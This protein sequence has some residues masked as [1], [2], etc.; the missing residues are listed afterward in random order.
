MSSA[1]FLLV[2]I[3]IYPSVLLY[4]FQ[5]ALFGVTAWLTCYWFKKTLFW[6]S[7]TLRLL[8]LTVVLLPVQGLNV[9]LMQ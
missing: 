1:R 4:N 8:V 6:H 7:L 2:A 3:S 5:R 9:R